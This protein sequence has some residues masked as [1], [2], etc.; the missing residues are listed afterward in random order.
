MDQEKI[1]KILTGLAIAAVVLVAASVWVANKK[2]SD[3]KKENQNFKAVTIEKKDEPKPLTTEEIQK[4]LE[5]APEVKP[6]TAEEI[7]AAMEKKSQ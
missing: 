7:Q 4:A 6:L 1:K 5:K 3:E 2:V